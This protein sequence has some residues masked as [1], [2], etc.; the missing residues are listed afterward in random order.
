M[1]KALSHSWLRDTLGSL[2]RAFAE[3]WVFSLAV[4]TL[5]LAVPVFVLQVYDRVVFHAG[6]STLQGLVA[7]MV[8]AIGFDFI[9]RQS[10][11]R[12]LQT[13]AMRVDAA[14]GRRLFDKLMALPLRALERT[15]VTDWN[16]GFRDVDVVRNT[17]SGSSALLLCEIPFALLFAVL[18]WVIAAP[19]AWVLLLCVPLM[20]LIAW[21][22]AAE[23]ASAAARERAGV[24]ERDSLISEVVAAR[25]TIKA[26]GCEA[27]VR[28]RWEAS[29]REA[30]E[31]AA[32]RGGRADSYA[33][34]GTMLTM[35]T[36][37]LL[38]SSGA[39]AILD[40]KMTIGALVAT[41]MLSGRLIGPLAQLVGAWRGLVAFTTAVERLGRVF[42][43]DEP[44]YRRGVAMARPHGAIII[45]GV[46][47]GFVEGAPPVIDGLTLELPATAGM[48][49]IVGA[50]GSGKT[51]LLKLIQGLYRPAQGRVLI[52]GADIG[53]FPRHELARWIAYLPQ[54]SV[55]FAGSI[56][57]CIALRHPDAS[58]AD[59]V[60]AA[61]RAG[62]HRDVAQMPQGYATDVGID[63]RRLSAGQRQRVIIA[64]ALLGD[65]AIVLLD[66][67]T[68][69][70]DRVAALELRRSLRAIA[71][72]CCV[73]MVTHSL[74]LLSA[75]DSVCRLEAGAVKM[76]GR[77][78]E[79]V[80]T[81]MARA[82]RR[83]ETTPPSTVTWPKPR[84][85]R[86]ETLGHESAGAAAGAAE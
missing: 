56:R 76:H 8:I 36:T 81:L 65:S 17:L 67:P 29:H 6:M 23:M 59:I 74:S 10:R 5:A 54:D 45:E 44:D 24:R 16:T 83:E 27:A 12:I 60:K 21:R 14:V 73:I 46:D 70:L 63:G 33:N 52:G 86:S 61:E 55:L 1:I 18:I 26:L 75:C 64:G 58:D 28:S 39:L 22:S 68:R 25:A 84:L 34:L 38:T 37:V 47:F 57:E 35:V 2:A 49:A 43:M 50:N 69:D 31:H 66:E 9:L 51:T 62:L 11:A 82:H 80:P 72:T 15:S 30:I 19:I 3:V 77:A 32:R 20:T 42:A 85:A 53:Q 79:I 40:Q 41:N 48:H 7:G 13:V 71:E 78:E 4:N